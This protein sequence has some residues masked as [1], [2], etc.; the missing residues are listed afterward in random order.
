VN[1]SDPNTG[2]SYDWDYRTIII[3]AIS[4][5]PFPHIYLQISGE[6]ETSDPFH[7]RFIPQS[8]SD[9]QPLFDAFSKGAELNPDPGT[10]L[11]S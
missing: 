3:H 10:L 6:D 8:E 5:E 11:I 9:L 4:R 1:W 2:A 7:V